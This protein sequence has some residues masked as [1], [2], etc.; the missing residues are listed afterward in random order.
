VI[1]C[2]DL[3]ER[4]ARLLAEKF[5]CRPF[6]SGLLVTTPY[7]L[8]DGDL[9]ELAVEGRPEGHIR[10]RDL[11]TTMAM[12]LAQGFDPYASDKRRWLLDQA[13]RLTGVELD[14]G[15]LKKDGPAETVGELLLDVAVAAR[16]VADLIYLH[17]SQEP[18][19]FE[20]RVVTFLSDHS[21]RV[22]AGAKVRGA[23]GREYRLTARV[24]RAD[25]PPLLVVALS[26]R[27]APQVKGAV[28]RTVRLWFDVNGEVGRGQK[29]SFIND[30][31]VA[32]PT[33]DL[34]LLNKL[35]LVAGWRNRHALAP[36]VAG[37]RS[38]IDIEE[39]LPLWDRSG[40]SPH[41]ER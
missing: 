40:E 8:P 7:Q 13:I 10:V 35:C 5:E 23:S 21:P 3:I 38:E 34:R 14:A 11:G 12:L 1:D 31:A 37:E 9:V 6:D 26:P 30:A 29:V 25:L 20:S 27:T 41:P 2:R 16:G 19:D 18:Q 28:D 22:D 17:R 15:E 4:H 24:H 39:A 32:W 33:P 36:V